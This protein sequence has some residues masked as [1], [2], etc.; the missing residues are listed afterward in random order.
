MKNNKLTLKALKKELDLIKA[1]KNPD[2]S[3]KK[4]ILILKTLISII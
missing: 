3:N 1:Y 4:L 2:L